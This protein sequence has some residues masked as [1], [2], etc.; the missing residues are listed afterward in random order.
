ME[1]NDLGKTK[2]CFASNGDIVYLLVNLKV[3]VILGDSSKSDFEIL[4][5]S[6]SELNW[7]KAAIGEKSPELT[8]RK[9]HVFHGKN[10]ISGLFSDMPEI[11]TG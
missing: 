2:D 7:L 3:C 10:A 6:C 11:G 5:Q 8:P 1:K 9:D 4:M